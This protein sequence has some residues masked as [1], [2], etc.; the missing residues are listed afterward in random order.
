M[1]A[2]NLFE[3]LVKALVVINNDTHGKLVSKQS[4]TDA[5]T[6]RHIFTQLILI[7]D[8]CVIIIYVAVFSSR[9]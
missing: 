4:L 1:L 6:V 3:C 2:I 5:L 7:N 9:F 8:N